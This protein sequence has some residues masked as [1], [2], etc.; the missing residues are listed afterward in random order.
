MMG[1]THIG[2]YTGRIMSIKEYNADQKRKYERDVE[3][4]KGSRS[5]N[6]IPQYALYFFPT[7]HGRGLRQTGYV[8]QT[9]HGAVW[10]KT[11]KGVVEKLKKV[12]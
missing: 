12:L 11:K 4:W 1:L 2:K 7:E 8:G 9:E 10:A 3:S 5:G 6:I